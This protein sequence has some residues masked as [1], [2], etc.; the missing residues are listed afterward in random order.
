MSIKRN[1]TTEIGVPIVSTQL[2]DS[3]CDNARFSIDKCCT[4]EEIKKVVRQI[5]SNHKDLLPASKKALIF[6]KPNLNSDMCGLTGNTT[7]LRILS[8]VMTFFKEQGYT[9]IVVG[10]G[11]SSGFINAGINVI[12]RLKIDRLAHEFEYKAF[13]LNKAES[14]T[15]KLDNETDIEIAKV[16]FDA[17]LFINLPKIKTHAEAG[18]SACLKNMIGCAVGLQKQKIHRN[19]PE[20]IVRLND[21]IKPDIHIVDGVMAM[22]GTGPSRGKPVKMGIIV[23]GRNPWLIDSVCSRL[24]SFSPAE[25]PYLRL[26]RRN[27]ANNSDI[28][29]IEWPV[30]TAGISRKFERPEASLASLINSPVYRK[31]F[32]KLR[33]QRLLFRFFSLDLI[34]KFLYLIKAR[35]DLFMKQD[36]NISSISFNKSKCT[37][38]HLCLDY[39]PMGF[40]SYEDIGKTEKCLNCLYCYFVC[41]KSAIQI[42]GSLGYLT[43]QMT[44]YV[45]LIQ[46]Q[47]SSQSF[48]DD[49]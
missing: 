25:V 37:G 33:Y 19:L 47:L 42:D 34:S 46:D 26:S 6:L 10:D 9:N 36:S 44:N 21:I 1:F 39:C 13:D 41:S 5:L 43:Y 48:S 32:V 20:N 11:T 7:D 8:A 29:N 4:T 31:F 18:I 15:F 2:Q 22:E 30:N 27:N 28:K 45:K 49:K 38:C 12:S 3:T 16:C 14:M 17:E 24:M 23:S 35:Q 40:V